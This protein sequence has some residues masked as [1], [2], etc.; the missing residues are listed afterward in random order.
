[1]TNEPLPLAYE[2]SVFL[3]GG[4][5]KTKTIDLL[6]HYL[7]INNHVTVNFTGRW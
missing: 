1:M 6:Y 5:K 3:G 4:K 2:V 7:I